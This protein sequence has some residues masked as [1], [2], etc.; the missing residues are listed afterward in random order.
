MGVAS[1]KIQSFRVEFEQALGRIK[2]QDTLADVHARFFP[3]NHGRFAGLIKEIERLGAEEKNQSQQEI[4][5]LKA[6]ILSRLQARG[7]ELAEEEKR[8]KY[9][10]L[11]LP[12]KS[13][14]RG[15]PHPLNVLMREI[16]GVFLNLGFEIETGP[17]VET[18]YYNFEALNLPAGHPARDE[19]QTFKVGENRFLRPHTFS[20]QIRV[21]E[22]R[23]PPVRILIPGKT[24]RREKDPNDFPVF[25]RVGG[26]VVGQGMALA[27]L[28]GMME[29]AAKALFHEKIR[30]RFRPRYFP[31]TEPSAALDINCFLCNGE[32][33]GC[34]VCR[35]RGWIEI[36]GGG[37]VHSQVFKNMNIDPEKFSGFSF[38]IRVDRAA[39]I[40]YRMPEIRGFYQ[41][42]I[43]MIRQCS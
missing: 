13:R 39:M 19:G 40:R 18:D 31:F 22:R 21:L 35:G 30:R 12:G 7:E 41:N 5:Q 23:K 10:D 36:A 9:L 37:M 43:W 33:R 4:E 32:K 26:L 15:A 24:Y 27:H 8:K 25:F 34:L 20:S 17:E 14:Y 1:K 29:Y 3:R 28:K 2:D 6:D 16:E 42:N 11:T 38:G